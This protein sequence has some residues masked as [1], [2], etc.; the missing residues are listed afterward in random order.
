[1]PFSTIGD[2]R[3]HFLTS[4]ANLS[5]KTDLQ[6]LVQE[7]TSGEK[8]DLTAHLGASQT[9]LNGID[10]QLEM[11]SSFTQSNTDTG[12]LLSTMQLA[13]DGVDDQRATS[14][15]A[16][17]AVTAASS[18]S[19]VENAGAISLA[20]FRTTV[21]TLNTRFG[22]RSMFGGND[23]SSNPMGD[24]DDILDALRVAVGGLT[25]TTDIEAAID[26][27]FD[28]PAGGF[29]TTGYLG[30]DTGV[31]VRSIDANQSVSVDVRADDQTLRDTLKAL[32]KGALAADSNL[33]L[34]L[35][36]RRS[37][38]QTAGVDL[39][40][41]A[42]PIAN[43]QARLGHAEQQ[44]EQASVRISA[45]QSS[46]GIARNDLVSADP[47]ETATRLQAVQQQLE[48]QYTL[49]ARLSRLSLTEYLR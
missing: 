43:L 13:L 18:S 20:S 29:E 40:S 11:L 25:S 46:Y 23:L 39:L 10:R 37:L 45:Q 44:V 32:A 8:S 26:T 4:R 30:D 17:L 35:D 9:K 1:M 42:S 33:T 36:T 12:Q 7:L 48:T 34:S 21:Q 6:T 16:L 31:I 5:L 28:T 22:D 38:Q 15:A 49:T 47:Y 27:W 41:T 24:P 2:M 14:S 3:Q 19:Q